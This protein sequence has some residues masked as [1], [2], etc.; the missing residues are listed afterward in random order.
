MGERCKRV[1]AIGDD[2]L[3][4]RHDRTTTHRRLPRDGHVWECLDIL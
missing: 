1:L 4:V 3:D 2:E